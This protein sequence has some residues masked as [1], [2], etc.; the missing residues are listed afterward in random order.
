VKFLQLFQP[1]VDFYVEVF[2][3]FFRLKLC[4]KVS[5]LTKQ[6][7]EF[8]FNKEILLIAIGYLPYLIGSLKKNNPEKNAE[9][10]EHKTRENCTKKICLTIY[11]GHK[12]E[13]IVN[14][15]SFEQVKKF[16]F[17]QNTKNYRTFYPKKFVIRLSKIWVWDPGSRVKKT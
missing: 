6:E 10:K 4:E 17:C 2:L 8:N 7:A 1:Q 16:Y 12:Y 13:R 14:N 5:S 9:T 15:F 3:R 11:C